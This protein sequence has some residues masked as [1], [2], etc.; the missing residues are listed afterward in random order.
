MPDSIRYVGHAM[1]LLGSIATAA[2]LLFYGLRPFFKKPRLPHTD[3]AKVVCIITIPSSIAGLGAGIIIFGDSLFLLASQPNGDWF[4]EIVLALLCS[5][6]YPL[7][8]VF[9]FIR[10]M[11]KDLFTQR[12]DR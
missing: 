3:F 12:T 11:K 4:M 10:R 2:I 1:L 9:I 5:C 8:I 7:G 6:S